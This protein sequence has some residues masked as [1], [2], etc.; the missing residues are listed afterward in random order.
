[1]LLRTDLYVEY[2]FNLGGNYGLQI[3]AN[4]TNL[5]NQQ[6]ARDIYPYYNRDNIYLENEQILAGYD[7]I[8]EFEKTGL[9]LDPRFLME[10]NYTNGIDVRL[11][12]RFIF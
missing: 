7:Y 8:E 1:M 12:I 6:I 5:F 2:N 4:I 9:R 11:G 10:R 3:N